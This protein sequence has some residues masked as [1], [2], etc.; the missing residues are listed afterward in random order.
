MIR[1]I[2]LVGLVMC[3]LLSI[4]YN[5]T[6]L[7][8][9]NMVDLSTHVSS[10]P[11]T[12]TVVQWHSATPVSAAT[13]L[14]PAQVSAAPAG[15]YYAVYYDASN[16]CYSPASQV[17]V[18]SN[19]C[20]A[21][22]VDLGAHVGTA[23]SGSTV[24][25]FTNSTHTGSAYATPTTAGT[26]TYYA[27]FYDV[28]NNCYSPASSPVIVTISTCSSSSI[29]V[30]NICPSTT[31]DLT[32]R[33]SSTPPAGT[34]VVWFTNS[35]HS[36]TAY[37]T[38]ATADAG[39]YYAFYYDAT[40]NC[41][42]PA[43]NGIEVVI[44]LCT[45]PDV[46]VTNI[47][48]PTSG[49]VSTND[50]VPVG[51][52][53]GTPVP[54]TGNPSVGTITMNLNG[55]Y[56]FTATIPGV[57]TYNVPVCPPGVTL[58]CPTELLTITVLDPSATNNL[59]IV[60]TD[61]ATTTTTTPVVI[62]SLA[63]DAA[64]NVGGSLN[65]ASVTVT[66]APSNGIAIV[67]SSTGDITY[68]ANPGFVGTDTITYQV[69]D[70][71]TPTPLCASAQQIVNVLPANGTND[72]PIAGDD[73]ATT[74]GTTPASGNILTNDTDPDGNTL[75]ATPQVTNIPGVGT[76]VLNAN[77][78]YTFTAVPGFSGPVDLPYT[79][80]D[81]GTPS[82]CSDATLHILVN[83][84][85]VTNPDINVSLINL[86]VSGDVSSNDVVPGGTTYGTPF[87]SVT[88]PSGGSITMNTD[89]TYTF[90]GT[91]PGVYTYLVPVC[92]QGQSVGCPS[93]L[94]SI[95]VTSPSIV[96]NP[97]TVNTD[98]GTTIAQA[99][100]TLNSL[101]ND[102]CNNLPTC[103]LDPSSVTITDAPS[104]GVATVNPITGAITYQANPGFFGTDTL[105][106]QVCDTSTTPDVCATAYQI[107]TVVPTGGGNRIGLND[108]YIIVPFGVTASGDVLD[109][110]T[111]PEN[112]TI[113]AV[114]QT[115]TIAGKGTLTL[116][117]DGT[118]TFVPTPLFVGTV[119][120]PYT[121]CDN[122]NPSVCAEATIYVTVSTQ[123]TLPLTW[124]SFTV[125]QDK[126]NAN[127]IWSTIDEKNVSHFKVTRKEAKDANFTVIAIVEAKN[128][129]TNNYIFTDRDL[130]E[131]NYQYQLQEV[132]IDNKM[133]NSEIKSIN[134]SCTM[135]PEISVWPNPVQNELN[136]NL[137]NESNAYNIKL[138]DM[139]GRVVKQIYTEVNGRSTKVLIPMSH[140]ADGIYQV[141]IKNSINVSTFKVIKK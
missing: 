62:N 117:S 49:N 47:N 53:Y 113:T 64:G 2:K 74:T 97:P 139:S 85:I 112:N 103:G 8:A 28:T 31:V 122:G 68:T 56:T 82:L 130:A 72:A 140:L 90:T 44:S 80:C 141:E 39:T 37:A 4:L 27:F 132:D 137:T 69:C 38:P 89:G 30:H 131:G 111:D 9:Q 84:E 102:A 135:M 16:N 36:G 96:N 67:N 1:N 40:N 13:L 119:T 46:M 54:S 5:P 124:N 71:S 57:Y 25:W 83:P 73:F 91:T 116:N 75:T 45:N 23:P 58:N 48:T 121:A 115:T 104:N 94:L 6:A 7:Q 88:N 41:Y 107:F 129:L 118:Y 79:V 120:I 59:P 100:I 134:M 78:F 34:S 101:S 114:P 32:A 22:T 109:N 12:G 14:S 50:N 29:Q 43:S 66:S 33:V 93:E 123:F 133:F 108:D 86:P 17:V 138:I 128:S 55:T 127:V 11:P 24:V 18:A 126:C 63:N 87:A 10:T 70:N 26:G 136:I 81:N 20:P 51:T 15:S 125:I 95:T 92:P 76:L 21:P 99:P 65:P 106:Y 42:S 105:T 60:N 35:A 3:L 52:T 110:D 98:L 61:L 77:G 19:V